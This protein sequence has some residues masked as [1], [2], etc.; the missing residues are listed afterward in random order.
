MQFALAP[1][2]IGFILAILVLIFAVLGVAGV[3][4]MTAVTVFGSIAVLA[5]ARMC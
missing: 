2:S 1:F 5:I 4:P 3:L